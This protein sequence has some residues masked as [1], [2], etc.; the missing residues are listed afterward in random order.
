M[1]TSSDHETIALVAHGPVS[2][3]QWRLESVTTRE[4]QSDEVLVRIVASGICL[5]D[6]HFGDSDPGATKMPGIWYPR[7]LGH[8]GSGYIEKVGSSVQGLAPT[9]P[10]ILSFNS[11]RDCFY[12]REGDAGYCANFFQ[13]NFIGEHGVYIKSEEPKVQIGGLFF[14]QSSFANRAIVKEACVVSVAH[15]NLSYEKLCTLAPLGCAVQTGTGALINTAAVKPGQSVAII[16]V[17]GV[18]QCAIMVR[19]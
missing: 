10:V 6:L 1:A 19:K 8:E 7:V 12:C 9:E 11:C 13:R 14:G 15:L 16:G 2:A 5:A 17:G 18:G 3:H 4:L